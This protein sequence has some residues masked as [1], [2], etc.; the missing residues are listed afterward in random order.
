MEITDASWEKVFRK[1]NAEESLLTIDRK[2]AYKMKHI[3]VWIEFFSFKFY[4]EC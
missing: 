2:V 3:M 4:A 1:Q